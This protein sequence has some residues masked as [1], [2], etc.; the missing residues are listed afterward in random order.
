[1]ESSFTLQPHAISGRAGLSQ[2][3]RRPLPLHRIR[4]AAQPFWGRQEPCRQAGR[5]LQAHVDS[6]RTLV[7][8]QDQ[9]FR[10]PPVTFTY[11]LKEP[12]LPGL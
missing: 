1:M 11:S 4:A 7:A 2:H 6:A 3:H 10:T 5:T 8:L 9:E 12:R